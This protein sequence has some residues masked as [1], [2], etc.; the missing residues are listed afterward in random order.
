MGHKTTLSE[1]LN[2]FENS[3]LK[4]YSTKSMRLEN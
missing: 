4:I 3:F 1:N 2:D